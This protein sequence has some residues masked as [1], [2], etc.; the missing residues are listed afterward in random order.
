MLT[1][2]VDIFTVRV[3]E[4]DTRGTAGRR[5]RQPHAGDGNEPSGGTGGAAQAGEGTGKS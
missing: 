1:N 3:A 4:G 2:K 5:S